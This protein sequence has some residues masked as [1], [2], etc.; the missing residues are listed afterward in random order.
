MK[1]QRRNNELNELLAAYQQ[2][3]RKPR[4]DRLNRL[5]EAKKA[6]PKPSIEN[7]IK[8]L[9]AFGLDREML[10]KHFES[11]RKRLVEFKSKKIGTEPKSLVSS[12][13]ECK[14]LRHFVRM[15]GHELRPTQIHE[16]Q[17]LFAE[18]L[19]SRQLNKPELTLDA[20]QLIETREYRRGFWP[21]RQHV[22][23]EADDWG[24]GWLYG[25]AEEE[26]LSWI[27]LYVPSTSNVRIFLKWAG[28]G[29]YRVYSDDDGWISS[30]AHAQITLTLDTL[31]WW[32]NT[33]M[34]AHREKIVFD[35]E[36][37]NIHEEGWIDVPF[38][39]WEYPLSVWPNV[40]MLIQVLMKFHCYARSDWAYSLLDFEQPEW[41]NFWAWVVE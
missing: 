4:V 15:H 29:F 17:P 5:F 14:N 31:Q 20:N 13:E 30:K 24:W 32:G 39:F 7:D 37:Q 36:G 33:I 26:E 25:N 41:V 8:S 3:I 22:K 6:R 10:S 38:E 27:G 35:L 23:V 12:A 28:K 40:D 21:E 11:K 18:Q 34:H 2:R 16:L 1:Y 19:S 9:A